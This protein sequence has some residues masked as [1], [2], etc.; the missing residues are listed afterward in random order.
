M[1]ERVLHLEIRGRV[2][3]VYYRA[4]MVE[5]ATALGVKGWVRNRP[6]G[7]VQAMIAGEEAVLQTLIEWARIG[8]ADAVV[9][10]VVVSEGEGFFEIFEQRQTG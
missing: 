6:D 10:E 2:Q 9:R 3:G 8:P 4:S 5:Q 1:S 7:S